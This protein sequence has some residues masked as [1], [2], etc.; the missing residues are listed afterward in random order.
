MVSNSFAMLLIIFFI[1]LGVEG[2]PSDAA[3][4]FATAILLVIAVCEVMI[5]YFWK[6]KLFCLI[7][8]AK[9]SLLFDIP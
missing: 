4:P 2:M 8:I 9:N 3:V 1:L 6:R 7:N 5:Y